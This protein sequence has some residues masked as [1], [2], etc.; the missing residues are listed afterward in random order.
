MVWNGPVNRHDTL[1]I[2]AIGE[3]SAI[4]TRPQQVTR[5]SPLMFSR[6]APRYEPDYPNPTAPSSHIDAAVQRV[7]HQ[8]GHTPQPLVKTQRPLRVNVQGDGTQ[9]VGHPNEATSCREIPVPLFDPPREAWG[10]G[11][12]LLFDHGLS[13]HVS[14]SLGARVPSRA[15]GRSTI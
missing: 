3:P 12:S 5:L 14:A 15:K 9:S 6:S 10:A 11:S 7:G 2:M 13:N 4:Q 8:L 1:G